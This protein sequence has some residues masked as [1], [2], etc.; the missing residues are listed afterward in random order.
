MLRQAQIM[1]PIASAL[2]FT[3]FTALAAD[4]DTMAQDTASR[5][6]P[7]GIVDSKPARGRFV[8]LG[9]GTW[10]VPYRE[11]IADGLSF[12]M[13]PI[14][15]GVATIGSPETEPR[16]NE[17]E[18]PQVQITIA[19]YWIGAMEVSWNEYSMFEATNKIFREQ[20]RHRK[21]GDLPVEI[22][23]ADAV[24]APTEL[25]EPEFHR[26]YGGEAHPA[27]TMTHFGAMQYSKWLT[28]TTGNQ[29]RLPT[30]AEWEHACRAGTTTAYSCGK[31]VTQLSKFARYLLKEGDTIEGP[32][33]VGSLEPNAWGLH[34]MHGNVAEWVIDQYHADAYKQLSSVL[35]GSKTAALFGT[36]AYP[37]VYRGG[38]SLDPAEDLR[39]ARRFASSMSFMDSDPDSPRSPHW[40]T[41]DPARFIGFRLARSSRPESAETIARFWNPDPE[42]ILDVKDR[43][44]QGRNVIGVLKPRK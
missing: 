5:P 33:P 44:D 8:D 35:P 23:Q 25:Y 15:G 28:L 21:P 34:D 11:T 38:S 40:H 36:Q 10:M 42:I 20:S 26:Q 18:G 6:L 29:Y 13:V 24:T 9:D 1:R 17:D 30:E 41:T 16:R 7:L 19:P 39:S 37:N 22:T 2:C 12:E 32:L 27:V 14:A 43:I 3:I 4:I 31:D